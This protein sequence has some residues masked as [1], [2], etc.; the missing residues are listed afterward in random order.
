MSKH[1]KTL[2]ERIFHAVSFE[3][4]AIAITA[5]VSA[6]LLGRSIFQM[7]TVAIVLSTLAMLLNVVYNMIF[8]RYWPLSKGPRP[9][10]V[11]VFHAIGFELSFVI[12]GVP[13]LAFLLKMSFLDAFLLE[14]GFFAFFLFYTYAF[15]LGYDNLRD[16]WFANKENTIHV[17]ETVVKRS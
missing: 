1:T 12:M 7:G 6:W 4:I 5:P 16:R 11:R 9:A 2:T 10:K 15:N 17:S 3:V 8:D 13:M 14:I